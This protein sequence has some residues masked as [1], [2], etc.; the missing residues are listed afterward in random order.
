VRETLNP[1]DGKDY[2]DYFFFPT[3]AETRDWRAAASLIHRTENESSNIIYQ[4][5]KG[6]TPTDFKSIGFYLDFTTKTYRNKDHQQ[7]IAHF[8]Q[9]LP[10]DVYKAFY[11]KLSDDGFLTFEGQI[12]N[13]RLKAR[14]F[15]NAHGLEIAQRVFAGEPHLARLNHIRGLIVQHLRSIP[16]T[17]YARRSMQQTAGGMM[18]TNECDPYFLNEPSKIKIIC[19]EID[20]IARSLLVVVDD[21]QPAMARHDQMDQLSKDALFLEAG[22]GI[23]ISLLPASEINQATFFEI[24]FYLPSR[25]EP[26][27]FNYPEKILPERE[28]YE[29][30]LDIQNV[31]NNSTPDMRLEGDTDDL[32]HRRTHDPEN[33]GSFK[34]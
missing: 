4:S 21:Q 14:Y 3:W 6:F 17:T 13:V 28:F 27:R 9:L 26:I 16:E 23:M 18:G 34:Y 33:G 24:N 30:L 5:D 1:D 22:P 8:E 2:Q 20:D 31:L 11:Q 32:T 15:I 10:P 29:T 25:T 7:K 12:K 19:Q